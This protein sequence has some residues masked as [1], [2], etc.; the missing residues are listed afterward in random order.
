MRF[1]HMKFGVSRMKFGKKW[2]E[3]HKRHLVYHIHYLEHDSHLPAHARGN[4][5]VHEHGHYLAFEV[6]QQECLR[7]WQRK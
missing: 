5:H 7:G 6:R 1:L 4:G 2:K 3:C